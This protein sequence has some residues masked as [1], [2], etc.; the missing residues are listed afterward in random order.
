MQAVFNAKVASPQLQEALGISQGG[1]RT[2]D[3]VVNMTN[4]IRLSPNQSIVLN[5]FC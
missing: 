3:A 2:G 4:L 5:P 1:W